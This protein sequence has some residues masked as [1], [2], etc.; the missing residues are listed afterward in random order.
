MTE[1]KVSPRKPRIT[2]K[3]QKQFKLKNI[4]ACRLVPKQKSPKRYDIQRNPEVKQNRTANNPKSTLDTAGTVG[5]DSRRRDKVCGTLTGNSGQGDFSW[6]GFHATSHQNAGFPTA[7]AQETHYHAWQ[8][9]GV[10]VKKDERVSVRSQTGASF[11]ARGQ[12]TLPWTGGPHESV[13]STFWP[14]DHLLPSHSS[15]C[16]K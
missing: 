1:D 15:T 6:V 2:R 3:Q 14:R 11:V 16:Y 5:P 8:E 10:V 9:P 7:G 4:H 12:L 13:P